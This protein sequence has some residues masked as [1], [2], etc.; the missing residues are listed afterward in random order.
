[1]AEKGLCCKSSIFID[2]QSIFLVSLFCGLCL[3]PMGLYIV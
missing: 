3:P 2:S 1:M